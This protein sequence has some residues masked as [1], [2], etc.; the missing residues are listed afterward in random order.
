MSGVE[1]TL[2]IGI[3]NTA[4]GDDALG[5]RLLERVRQHY[6]GVGTLEVFQ[7]QIE[8]VLDLAGAACVLF[9]D[10]AIGLEE[11]CA[12]HEARAEASRLA[13]SHAMA[14]E[15]LLE[16]FVR[17]QGRPP[18]PAFVLALR[19]DSTALGEGLSPAGEEALR[20]GWTIVRQLLSDPSPGAWR[21][22]V[23]GG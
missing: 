12:L 21:S 8:H 19:A 3:G 13:F 14:P 17:T 20:C 22:R 7:L 16:V 1:R 4:R 6:P 15:A 9:C 11:P 5:V 10:A 2:V 23:R 18:P